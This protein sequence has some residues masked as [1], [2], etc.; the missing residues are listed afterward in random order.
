CPVQL[1]GNAPSI[2]EVG[3]WNDTISYELLS[4]VTRRPTWIYQS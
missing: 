3:S 2:D 1:W 4:V